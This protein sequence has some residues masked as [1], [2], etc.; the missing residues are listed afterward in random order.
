MGDAVGLLVLE[1]ERARTLADLGDF[2]GVCDV[3]NRGRKTT[4]AGDANGY[5]ERAALWKS[6][7]VAV[8]LACHRPALF[9]RV[10][11]AFLLQ[12]E[13]VQT[14]TGEDF[15][16]LTRV[17]GGGC[18][19]PTFDALRAV[20]S[21]SLKLTATIL[22]LKCVQ[23]AYIRGM[24]PAGEY[25]F[26]F[27]NQLAYFCDL[28]AYAATSENTLNILQRLQAT[29]LNLIPAT[30]QI[31]GQNGLIE[32]RLRFTRS[33][34]RYDLLIMSD[35][36]SFSEQTP[37]SPSSQPISEFNQFLD[38]GL[39]VFEAALFRGVI[40]AT[41]IGLVVQTQHDEVSLDSS[42]R[43]LFRAPTSY[44]DHDIREWTLRGNKR[45][46]IS[47]GQR[48]ELTNAYVKTERVQGLLV[49]GMGPGVSID[50]IL[51]EVDIN[52]VPENTSPRL[53]LDNLRHFCA[54]S[55][56]IAEGLLAEIDGA[57]KS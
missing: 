50:Y 5:I 25:M 51:T 54:T 40:P 37:P 22:Q 27:R 36:I 31:M 38:K 21:L 35:R 56:G 18:L 47:V 7:R 8:G 46:A 4:A 19:Q 13:Q 33:D 9:C 20:P 42:Y 15:Q 26:R 32:N 10:V 3:I 44:L 1:F 53:D 57:L 12:S 34:G 28:S 17:G 11:G 43:K 16:L 49:A 30:M 45:A 41:R 52:T 23:V 2:D 55:V 6:G 29:G 39:N 24:R 48:S 14:G